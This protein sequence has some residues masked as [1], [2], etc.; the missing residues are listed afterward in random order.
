MK[1]AEALQ[2]RADLSRRIEQLKDR[3]IN[4]AL[5]QEGEEPA[6]DPQ[7]L[8]KEFNKCI[9]EQTKL[10]AAINLA[11]AIVKT[12]DKT[13]TEMLAER[14]MLTVQIEAYRA[15]I[16]E[17]STTWQ[18]ARNSEIRILSSVN[19]RELTKKADQ[20]SKQLRQLENRIQETNWT[21]E[22]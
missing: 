13:L 7:E 18:R 19:V 20:L 12:G 2:E 10:I 22:I 15:L 8:L 21:I 1:L 16:S 6:E 4:N 17:A 3:M 11:N 5:I 9:K 14:D